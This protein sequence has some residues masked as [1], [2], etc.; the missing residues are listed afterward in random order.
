MTTLGEML[1]EARKQAGL[2]AHD[3][4]QRTRIMQNAIHA[5]EGDRH[6]ALPVAGYVRGYI[7]SYCKVCGVNPE[8]YL[9]QYERQSGNSRRDSISGEPYSYGGGYL[10]RK[11]EHEMTWKVVAI[12]ALA[13]VAVAVAIYF[14]GQSGNDSVPELTPVPAET[15][16]TADADTP[17]AEAAD[18]DESEDEDEEPTAFSF[19][20]EA[21][22]GRASNIR[23]VIDGNE[24]FSGSLT[25]GDDAVAQDGVY[26]VE[27][28]IDSPENLI[29]TRG[30]YNI[31]IPDSGEFTMTSNDIRE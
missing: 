29:I 17:E 11:S 4:A 7:L 15:T 10:T 20:V 25:S 26:E 9:E 27:F 18:N 21:R 30:E 12:A 2:S 8:P 22:E 16:L 3:V 14:I 31:V 19:S 24:Y 23:V 13:V 5:L 1:V 6:N 28:E